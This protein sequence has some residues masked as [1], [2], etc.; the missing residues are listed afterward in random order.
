M[1]NRMMIS[2]T[3]IEALEKIL[4]NTPVGYGFQ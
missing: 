2:A 1:L 3:S 4:A